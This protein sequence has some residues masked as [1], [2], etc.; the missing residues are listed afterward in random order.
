MTWIVLILEIN[1]STHA[2][3]PFPDAMSCG[4]ALPAIHGAVIQ[5]HPEAWVACRDS[6]IAKVRPKSRPW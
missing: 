1:S 4:R 2:V 5:H 6:G 3:I